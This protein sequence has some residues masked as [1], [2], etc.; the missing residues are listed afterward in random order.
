MPDTEGPMDI[1]IRKS[2]IVIPREVPLK[3]MGA[4]TN[5]MLNAPISANASPKAIMASSDE[6]IKRVGW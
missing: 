2:S 6:I 4:E 1:P 5:D 3:C